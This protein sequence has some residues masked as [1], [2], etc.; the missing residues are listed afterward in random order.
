MSLQVKFSLKALEHGF[1]FSLTFSTCILSFITAL[2][3]ETVC[4]S[5]MA[6]TYKCTW[7]LNPEEHHHPNCHENLKY[8]MFYSVFLE[9]IKVIDTTRSQL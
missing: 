5:E 2:K 9:S 8:H 4:F 3:M 1:K 7:H 6:S